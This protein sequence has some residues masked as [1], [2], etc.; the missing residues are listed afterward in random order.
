MWGVIDDILSKVKTLNEKEAWFFVI[1]KELKDEII[2]LNTQDQLYEDGIDS[3]NDSLGDYSSYTIAI[4]NMK[5]Q[6]T[7]NI[8]LK[9][10]GDFYKS[11]KVK[12][13][14]TGFT[15]KADDSTKYDIPLTESFGIDI[16]GLT[17]ENKLFLYDYLEE[18]YNKYVRK[19]LFQ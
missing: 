2:R 17:E 19:K 14:A 13:T 10:T 18:N 3:L 5:G 4:K 16:L 12:V 7:S 6:K 15:I 9:D 8:T 11:F 1:D